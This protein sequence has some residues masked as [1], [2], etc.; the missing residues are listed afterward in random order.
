MVDLQPLE[1]KFPYRCTL[2][3]TRL[4]QSHIAN[5]MELQLTLNIV[6]VPVVDQVKLGMV[7]LALM[8]LGILESK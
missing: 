1:P 4:I 3:P 6:L 7:S 8:S 2:K 5:T